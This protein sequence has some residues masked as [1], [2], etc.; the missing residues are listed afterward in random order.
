MVHKSILHTKGAFLIQK[1]STMP[2]I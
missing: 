1:I 2:E